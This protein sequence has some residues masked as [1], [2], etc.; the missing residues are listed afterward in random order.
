MRAPGTGTH[1]R[2]CAEMCVPYGD[3]KEPHF[4]KNAFDAGEDG[5][6]TLGSRRG[7]D[8][9]LSGKNANSLRLGCDCKG[10]IYYFDAHVA[11]MTGEPVTM[12]NCICMHEEDWSG[13][14]LHHQ[15]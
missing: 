1:V 10:A 12:E 2:S 15:D 6:G 13:C 3:P 5:L 4:R 14:V 11:S 9:S 8:P 7:A